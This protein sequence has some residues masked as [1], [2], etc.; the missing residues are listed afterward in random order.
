MV[1][2]AYLFKLSLSEF[3]HLY[4]RDNFYLMVVLRSNR[5]N[6]CKAL[7]IVPNT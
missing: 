5:A 4:N 3:P 7:K 2:L 6:T 1:T